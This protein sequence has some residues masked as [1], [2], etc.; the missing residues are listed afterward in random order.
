MDLLKADKEVRRYE[1]SLSA[2]RICKKDEGTELSGN[3]RMR[4]TRTS[5]ANSMLRPT[6]RVKLRLV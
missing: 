6:W 1:R 4:D 3:E 2:S 5:A